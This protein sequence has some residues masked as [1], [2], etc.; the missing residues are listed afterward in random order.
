MNIQDY[1]QTL[2]VPRDADEQ[3]IRKAYRK[4]AREYHPDLNPDDA[5]AQKKFQEVN[6]AHEVLSDPEKRKR[7]DRFGKDWERY[8]QQ[9]G[10]FDWGQYTNMGGFP[11]GGFGGQGASG[12]SDLF[13]MLFGQGGMNQGGFSQGG[14][15][16]GGFNQGGFRSRPQKGQHIEQ[17]VRITLEEAFHGSSRTLSRGN[18]RKEFKIPC[19]VDTGSKI[20][21]TG[22]GHPSPNG[23]QPGNLY[24]VV[25]VVPHKQYERKGDRLYTTF[26]LPLYTALLGGTVN[27]QTLEGTVDLNI[28]PETQ[29]GAKFR[30]SG[31]GMP[32]LKKPDQRG[33]MIAE[34]RV[35]LPKNLTAKQQE[36]FRQL[37][38]LG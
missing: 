1:Y 22:E 12:F 11:N 32:S 13:E 27:V 30:L 19:G 23:G 31:Q 34:A 21:L 25:D 10:D 2:G 37:Q 38:D 17:Q 5:T 29:N 8:Q 36:L 7:Y 3:T 24:I 26:D 4:L 14:F 6:E 9:G 28:P 16:Q 15:S 20:K 35:I 33:D 18:D